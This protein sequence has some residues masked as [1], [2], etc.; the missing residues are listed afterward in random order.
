[1]ESAAEE[2]LI[3]FRHRVFRMFV[4]W[5]VDLKV[6]KRLRG[7]K[8]RLARLGKGHVYLNQIF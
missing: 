3:I 8:F 5:M 6:G 7:S 2:L 4:V 1:M